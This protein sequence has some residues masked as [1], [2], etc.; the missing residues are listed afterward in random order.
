MKN[1]VGFGPCDRHS[2]HRQKAAV[3]KPITDVQGPG[4][5]EDAESASLHTTRPATR[6]LVVSGGH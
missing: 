3:P 6:K 4:C 1:A 2:T 5:V